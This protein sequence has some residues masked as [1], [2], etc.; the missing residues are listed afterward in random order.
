MASLKGPGHASSMSALRGLLRNFICLCLVIRQDGQH[1]P[2]DLRN[3]P[4]KRILF[5]SL[6][7]LLVLGAVAVSGARKAASPD[8]Q[9]DVEARNPWTNLQ[10]NNGSDTFHF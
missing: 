10:F 4:M 1:H 2:T 9:I 3:P 7:V 5:A 6:T 8:L